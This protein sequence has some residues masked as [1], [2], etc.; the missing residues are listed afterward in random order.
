MRELR[1]DWFTYSDK[2]SQ[3]N[4]GPRTISRNAGGE[5]ETAICSH[6]T[7]FP[8]DTAIQVC[9]T[10]G[11]L[12]N[13]LGLPQGFHDGAPFSAGWSYFMLTPTNTIVTLSVF[14]MRRELDGKIDSLEIR[15]GIA[16]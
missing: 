2:P 5:G 3:F 14:S 16:R 6:R 11:A 9:T 15:R 1:F 13:L 10:I 12:T 4:F 8:S 7:E